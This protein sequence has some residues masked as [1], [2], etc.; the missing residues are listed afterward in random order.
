MRKVRKT[1][2]FSFTSGPEDPSLSS[3]NVVLGRSSAEE[4]EE[5]EEEP[6]LQA[7]APSCSRTRWIP[8]PW[9]APAR[10][11][12][13]PCRDWAEKSSRPTLPCRHP[14]TASRGSRYSA[15]NT[16]MRIMNFTSFSWFSFSRGISMRTRFRAAMPASSRA[17]PTWGA[18][19]GVSG[20]SQGEGPVGGV[21]GESQWEGPVGGASG[22]SQ[23]EESVGGVSERSQSGK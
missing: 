6:P 19:G 5:E 11:L 3:V 20:R 4:E 10:S 16:A 18:G 8:F 12:A 21:S 14:N 1:R 2:R 22:E 23:G 17:T 9:A 15:E 7:A 13:L